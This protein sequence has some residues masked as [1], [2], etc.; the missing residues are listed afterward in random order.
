MCPNG[1]EVLVCSLQ[2][3]WSA[4][5]TLIILVYSATI[6]TAGWRTGKLILAFIMITWIESCSRFTCTIHVGENNNDGD[7]RNDMQLRCETR[8]HDTRQDEYLNR[9]LSAGHI[10][11]SIFV[12]F[13]CSLSWWCKQVCKTAQA[14]RVD[15][16]LRVSTWQTRVGP[17]FLAAWLVAGNQALAFVGV[18][19]E[20]RASCK[21]MMLVKAG[22]CGVC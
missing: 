17:F 21:W 12:A 6:M 15:R 3:S 5:T 1:Y 10:S 18:K 13:Y 20:R 2:S 22:S 16:D 19:L 14:H 8:R 9:L 11:F 4:T 7:D